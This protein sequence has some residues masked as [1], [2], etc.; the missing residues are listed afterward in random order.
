MTDVYRDLDGFRRF[1]ILSI[2]RLVLYKTFEDNKP[3]YC[4]S[5]LV[6]C[7]E[8][9]GWVAIWRRC[10]DKVEKAAEL[11]NGI[12]PLARS[13]LGQLL[14]VVEIRLPSRGEE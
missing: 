11:L 1:L 6:R 14:A 10:Y 4:V 7:E 9:G 12:E 2:F 3:M 5:L 13:K 8:P